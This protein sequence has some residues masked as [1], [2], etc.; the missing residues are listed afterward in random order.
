MKVLIKKMLK[1]CI[2]D[3]SFLEE[4]TKSFIEKHL[5]IKEKIKATI[6]LGQRTYMFDK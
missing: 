5:E 3:R 2:D 1:I 4:A 6:K